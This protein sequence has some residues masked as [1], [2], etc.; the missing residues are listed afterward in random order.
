MLD[1]RNEED[2]TVTVL[3]PKYGTG[4]FGRWLSSRLSRPHCAVRLD[5]YGS[6]VWKRCDGRRTIQQIADALGERCADA[7]EDLHPRLATF[8]R[9]L[10][11]T[12]LIGWADERRAFPPGVE[13]R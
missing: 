9:R 11:R 4:R 5:E 8:F 2:G 3:R 1:W 13:I 10:E 6:F 7:A 12:G